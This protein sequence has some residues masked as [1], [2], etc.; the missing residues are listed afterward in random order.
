MPLD[1]F[2]H[3]FTEMSICRTINT[4]VFS[5]S[6]TWKEAQEFGSW[7]TPHR[8]GGC[9][10]NSESFLNN[11]QYRLDITKDED[12]LIVQLSQ[13]DVRCKVSE[14]KELLVIGFHIMKVEEN[15]K[16]RLHQVQESTATSD[17]IKT[18][19]IFLKTK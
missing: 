18:K 19:H 6:K 8:A 16:F 4:S 1:D 9:L 2:L 15:R 17:Y 5:F 3:Q 13:E 7:Q 10:N 11:P 14:Q 12:D